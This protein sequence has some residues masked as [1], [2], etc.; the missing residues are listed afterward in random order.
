MALPRRDGPRSVSLAC[1]LTDCSN[2]R[3]SDRILNM[4]KKAGSGMAFLA[5]LHRPPTLRKVRQFWAERVLGVAKR[6]AS[7]P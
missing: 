5:R 7:P 3:V 4:R 6:V 1:R 2:G